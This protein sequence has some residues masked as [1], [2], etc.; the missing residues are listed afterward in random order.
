M[1][2]KGIKYF[3]QFDHGKWENKQIPLHGSLEVTY[4]CNHHCQHCSIINADTQRRKELSFNQ[5]RNILDEIAE[6]GCLWLVLTGGEPFMR[7]DFLDIYK[8]AKEKGILITIATNATSLTPEIV[9]FLQEYPPHGIQTTLFSLKERN[10]DAITGISGSFDRFIRGF[11]L[12]LSH[13]IPIS[14]VT[15]PILVFNKDD[16][17]DVKEYVE[18]LG[19][20]FNSYCFVDCTIDGKDNLLNYALPP[21]EVVGYDPIS[22]AA[23][24]I[25]PEDKCLPRSWKGF[26]INPYGEM[27]IRR[28]LPCFPSN[29]DISKG[30]F[31]KNWMHY[32]QHIK[33]Y[34]DNALCDCKKC[35][36]FSI[37]G[38]C[39]TYLKLKQ[40][41]SKFTDYYCRI[42]YLRN[43]KSINKQW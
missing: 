39:A 2:V 37:C 7:K 36:L 1:S 5:V 18:R 38:Q 16:I 34:R 33:S 25:F 28:R 20:N 21:E 41:K 35:S 9:D 29:L 4:S 3:N 12:L 15:T 30:G 10:F 14:A 23:I 27:D 11:N 8:Y 42:A 32:L 13:R 40:R 24:D 17:P 43:R 31:Y 19:I 22:I 26:V 6:V